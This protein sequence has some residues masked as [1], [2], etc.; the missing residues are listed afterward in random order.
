MVMQLGYIRFWAATILQATS[1]VGPQ[2]VMACIRQHTVDNPRSCSD[3]VALN[4]FSGHYS[5]GGRKVL[6]Y[7]V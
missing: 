6:N 1:F 3:T 5:E 7:W 2:S 4:T